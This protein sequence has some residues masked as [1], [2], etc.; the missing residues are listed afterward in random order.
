M[1]STSLPSPPAARSDCSSGRSWPTPNSNSAT[2]CSPTCSQATAATTWTARILPALERGLHVVS[3]RY[4]YSSLA[5]QSLVL[6]LAPVA[7][8]N[9]RFRAPDLTILLD[10]DP[11][12]CLQRI[13]RRGEPRD[14]FEALDRLRAVHDA[15]EAVVVYARTLG[16]AIARVDAR[17]HVEAVHDRVI[18]A[19]QERLDP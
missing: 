13:M 1:P 17:G 5:Y 4:T 6:G 2:P 15:Y 16:E 9:A 19:V 11:Q 12:T 14:R 3:D 10:L 18:A 7:E 8:L